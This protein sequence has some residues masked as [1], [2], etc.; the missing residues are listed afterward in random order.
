MVVYVAAYGTKSKT[1]TNTDIDTKTNPNQLSTISNEELAAAFDP[2]DPI[3]VEIELFDREGTFTLRGTA[4]RSWGN[5]ADG[6]YRFDTGETGYLLK[7]IVGG[8]APY[9]DGLIGDDAGRLG[10]ATRISRPVF[11]ANR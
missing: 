4:H 2:G 10:R 8:G 3:E 5:V 7:T 9:V 11:D 6:V 1:M